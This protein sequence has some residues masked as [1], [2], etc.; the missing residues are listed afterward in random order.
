MMNIIVPMKVMIPIKTKIISNPKEIEEKLGIVGFEVAGIAVNI[1]KMKN[2]TVATIATGMIISIILPVRP[3][4]L[5]DSSDITILRYYF[6]TFR[7]KP[8]A[9]IKAS[10]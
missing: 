1:D 2:T 3:S 5:P 4:F 6:A 10:S 7:N 9:R 8:F